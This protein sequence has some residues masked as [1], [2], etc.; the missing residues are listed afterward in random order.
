MAK[1]FYSTSEVANLFRVNRVTI[2]RWVKDGKVKAYGI[3][4]H[5]KIPLSE[6]E[7]LLGKFGFADRVPEN[8]KNDPDREKMNSIITPRAKNSAPRKLVV[9]IDDEK[10]T[11]E[12]I[13]G[14]F[15]RKK[16]Q[17]A[18][19]LEIFSDNLEA[20]MLIGREKPDVVLLDAAMPGFNGFALVEKVEKSNKNVRIVVMTHDPGD[21]QADFGKGVKIFRC[22]EKPITSE[23]LY[24][25]IIAALH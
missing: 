25:T 10:H 11:V 2:Y 3:G 6:V 21:R 23:E 20:A 4:K 13:Q 8:G 19:R 18:C 1:L 5:L 12:M 22:L 15:K 24:D 7:R 16:L 14:V 9:A 17:D